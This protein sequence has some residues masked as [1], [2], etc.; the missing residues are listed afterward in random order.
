M[1]KNEVVKL[2][3]MLCSLWPSQAK[4]FDAASELSRDTWHAML[5]GEDTAVVV[6]ALQKLAATNKFMPSIADILEAVAEI[7]HPNDFIDPDEAWG[8]VMQSIKRYGYMN[9][10]KALDAMPKIVADTVRTM[11]WRDLCMSENIAIDRGQFRKAYE[12]R[13]GR[14]KERAQLP[15]AVSNKMTALVNGLD[16]NMKM[17]EG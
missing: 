7:K 12:I 6:T 3:A 14:V 9:G 10:E 15:R 2:F 1:T 13:L 16:E 8:I 17:I 4:N 11:G 5:G